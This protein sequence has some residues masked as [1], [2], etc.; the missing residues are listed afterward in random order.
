MKELKLV[1]KYNLIKSAVILVGIAII[2]YFLKTGFTDYNIQKS[3]SACVL[4][5]KQTSE[6]YDLEKAR[7]FCKE[8]IKKIKKD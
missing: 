3:V 6:S 1:P 8:K 2:F 4:A 7:K 5:K